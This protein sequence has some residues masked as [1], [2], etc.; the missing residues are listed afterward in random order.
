MTKDS[1]SH[2]YLKQTCLET[3]DKTINNEGENDKGSTPHDNVKQT[4]LVTG[5][6]IIDNVGE[7][8]KRFHL[9]RLL[10]ADMMTDGV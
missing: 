4:W 2:N 3:G 10:K 6:K 9:S 1:T 7:N 8:D 5:F